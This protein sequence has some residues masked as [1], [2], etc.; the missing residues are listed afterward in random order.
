MR[1]GFA[2]AW[3]RRPELTWSGTSWNLRAALR[4]RAAA[5][6]GTQDVVDVVDVGISYPPAVRLALKAACARRHDGRWVSLWKHSRAA[7]RYGEVAVRGGLRR[8]QPDV[9]LQVQDLAVADRPYLLFQDLSYDVLADYAGRPD[10]LVNFPS[11]SAGAVARLRER[12]RRVYAGA[13]GVLAMSRWFADHLVDVSGLPADRVHVVHPGIGVPGPFGTSPS[14]TTPSGR[15]DRGR[16]DRDRVGRQR[17]RLLFV[18]R[19]FHRKGGE[20]VLAA[21]EVLRREVDP[22]VTLTVAGPRTWP[23]AGPVPTGVRFLGPVPVDRV[24]TLYADHDLFVLP[25]RF[26]AFG[27]VFVEALAAGLPCVGRRAFAMPEIITPGRNGDL[28]GASEGH[29]AA[30][31]AAEAVELASVVA[32]VLADDGIYRSTAAGA[33]EVTRHFSWQRAADDVL[34]IAGK[35]AGTAGRRRLV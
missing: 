14:G 10:G 6:T 11:L 2:C 33:A 5:T 7:R 20:V 21:L 31:R 16:A 32:Q 28:I 4:D 12:Q 3:D 34:G 9:L 25:S 19:D 26:E 29:G 23:L 1:L 24:G 18:G 17:R 8:H 35:V 30:G 22:A 15:P 13:A 27:I